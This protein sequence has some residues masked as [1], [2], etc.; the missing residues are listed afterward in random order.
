MIYIIVPIFVA[1]WFYRAARA[2]GLNA[3]QWSLIGFAAC[4][5][6]G[7]LWVTIAIAALKGLWMQLATN[8]GVSEALIWNLIVGPIG[9]A[10][11]VIAAVFV[12]RKYIVAKKSN[13]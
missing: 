13:A 8:M 2:A 1:I 11:E 9:I 12:R 7:V 4:L 5:L 3:P 6:P 10:L